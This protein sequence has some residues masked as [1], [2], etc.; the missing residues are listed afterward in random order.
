MPD[1]RGRKGPITYPIEHDRKWA[2]EIWRDRKSAIASNDYRSIRK[3]A[4]VLGLDE[5]YVQEEI[6]AL[7]VRR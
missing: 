1:R 5:D 3:A 4:K 2:E 6:E 7:T